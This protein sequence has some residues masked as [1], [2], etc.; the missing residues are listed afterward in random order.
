[1]RMEGGVCLMGALGFCISD[2]N[3]AEALDFG[4]NKEPRREQS[5]RSM[6]P[7]RTL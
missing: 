3:P 1:M 6:V 5:D 2:P 4:K 7:Q